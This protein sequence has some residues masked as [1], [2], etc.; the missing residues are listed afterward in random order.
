[1][2]L[3]KK[4][5]KNKLGF[6]TL[7]LS[8]AVNFPAF[9]NEND[10]AYQTSEVVVTAAGFEQD[11]TDAPATITVI[12]KEEI[13]RRGY[14]DLGDILADVPG[15]DVRGS[16]GRMGVADI[17]IRGMSSQY[18][19][20]MIDGIPQ[21]GT[22]DI[23]PNGYDVG[24]N[25]FVPPLASIERIEVIKGPMSTLYGSEALG[26]VVNIIT[27]KVSNEWKRNITVD[28]TMHEDSDRGS[29]TRYSFYLTGPLET[30]KV[31][32]ILRGNFLRR[33]GSTVKNDKGEAM[34]QRG[35]SVN[36][37]TLRNHSVGGKLTWKLDDR[38]SVW[39]DADTAVSDFDGEQAMR[40]ERDKITLGSDNRTSYGN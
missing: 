4:Q 34:A 6:L 39:L 29:I 22:K 1:M 7:A 16:T 9:A 31:G 20:V 11:A 12:T 2:K 36:P 38:N 17:S 40:Y 25:S 8:L 21:N 10:S 3:A 23:G 32:L 33:G 13:N 30:D 24:L 28:Y 37:A 19:M 14:T 27:K 18:T 26:G 5:Y 15:V 35:A